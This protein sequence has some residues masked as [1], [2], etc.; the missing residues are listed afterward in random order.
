M[1]TDLTVERRGEL[2][3]VE[4][5]R[6]PGNLFT[7]P[8]CLDLTR[9]LLDP[10]ESAR[11]LVLSAAGPNFCLGRERTAETPEDVY[12]MTQ[13]LANLNVALVTSRLVVI[14]QI[15]GDAAGFGVGLAALA[16]VAIA[17]ETARFAF[18]EAEAGLAPALVLTWLPAALG[19]RLAFWLT[20]TGQPMGA[21]TAERA[22]LINQAV[23][24]ERLQE[25]VGEATELLLHQP[26]QVCAEIKRDLTVFSG[27]GIGE[28]SDRAVERLALRSLVLNG[29]RRS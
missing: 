9:L 10:T 25:A 1:T 16:D 11:V 29:R 19:R 21:G 2:I 24:A 26:A 23:P 22:G 20:A 5:S 15:S 8:M 27:L 12:A 6:P 17:S 3:R 4:I 18:P 14:S 28:A 7:L 13:A